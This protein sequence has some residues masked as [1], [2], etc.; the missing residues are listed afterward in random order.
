MNSYES[1]DLVVITSITYEA[2]MKA[3]S[4]TA[5]EKNIT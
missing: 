5:L 3:G 2:A 4:V 1:M